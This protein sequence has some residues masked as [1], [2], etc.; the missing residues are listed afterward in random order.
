MKRHA[1]ALTAFTHADETIAKGDHLHLAPSQ[2][3][4]WSAEGV[5]LVR[6]ATPK[7]IEAAKPKPDA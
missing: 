1:V 5:D 3:A 4:D 2:F 6:A 7:E